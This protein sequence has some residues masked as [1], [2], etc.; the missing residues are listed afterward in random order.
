M[1]AAR[2]G[3]KL[4]R[5]IGADLWQHKWVLL[6]ASLVVGNALVVVYTSH[7]NR[8]LTSEWDRLLKQRDHLDIQWRHLLL[9]E[10]TQAEHSRVSR[11]ADKQLGM[12]RPA[13]KD[14]K[15][16]RLP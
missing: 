10:Q 9:E 1:A 8:N 4:W 12:V 2:E 14:E 3:I 11:V 15:V 5:V 7:A 16:V 6:L 13:P